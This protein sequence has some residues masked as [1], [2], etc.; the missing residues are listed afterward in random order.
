MS[1]TDWGHPV[2]TSSMDEAS[3]ASVSWDDPTDSDSKSIW[4]KQQGVKQ[5]GVN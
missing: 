5:Q 1:F 2:P 3:C 4:V